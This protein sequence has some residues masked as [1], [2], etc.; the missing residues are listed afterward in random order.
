MTLDSANNA[1]KITENANSILRVTITG[2][3]TI[4]AISVPS[5]DSLTFTYSSFSPNRYTATAN[6]LQIYAN[7]YDD[8]YLVSTSGRSDGPTSTGYN[9]PTYAGIIGLIYPTEE[10]W[11]DDSD[12]DW[13]KFFLTRTSV[14]GGNGTASQRYK[15]YLR[16]RKYA[17][18][19]DAY[20]EINLI[21][22]YTKIIADN[23]FY[24]D[25]QNAQ[26][27][28]DTYNING[29]SIQVNSNGSNYFRVDLRQ[30]HDA[31]A[32]YSGN[33]S[34]SVYGWDF[35]GDIVVRF[36]RVNNGYSLF[37]PGGLQVYQGFKNYMNE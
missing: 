36:G 26:Y 25:N 22:T 2:S 8:R 7:G 23:Y 34:V 10:I 33:S 1:W 9:N 15:L 3:T 24:Q 11:I 29:A 18:F 4:P 5:Q 30:V 21:D 32:T 37:G 19:N 14:V 20:N 17:N 12:I 16:V 28:T 27:D 6:S 35:N 13:A 31:T